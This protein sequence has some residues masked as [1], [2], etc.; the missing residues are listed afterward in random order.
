MECITYTLDL[1][2]EDLLA[3]DWVVLAWEAVNDRY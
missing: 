3:K 2:L 1:S